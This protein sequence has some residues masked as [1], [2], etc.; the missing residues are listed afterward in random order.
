MTPKTFIF[1]GRSGCGKGTQADLLMKVIKEKDPKRDTYY[2]ETGAK[3]R[4]FLKG[5]SFSSKLSK[6][7]SERGDL[8]PEF[9]SIY[10]WANHLIEDLKGDEHL[11]MDGTPRKLHE[12]EVLHS[13]MEFY[14]REK[15]CVIFMNVSRKWSEDRLLARHRQDDGKDNVKKRLDWYDEEVV[16]T[17]EYYRNNQNYTFLDINGERTIEEIHSDIISKLDFQ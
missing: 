16:P 15:P 5:S 1:I 3:F 12:A 8:Q 9:L 14:K 11:F 6:K 10:M 17:V 2:M 13:A 7:V 4:D